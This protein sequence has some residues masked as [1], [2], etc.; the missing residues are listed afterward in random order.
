MALLGSI[1]FDCSRRAI[2]FPLFKRVGIIKRQSVLVEEALAV[3][4]E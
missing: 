3:L 4:R 1:V 2:N